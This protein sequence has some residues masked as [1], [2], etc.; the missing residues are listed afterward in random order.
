MDYLAVKL[1]A[2]N[3]ISENKLKIITGM[4]ED[5][6]AEHSRFLMSVRRS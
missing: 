1:F 2:V 6:S 5:K 3:K 4:R